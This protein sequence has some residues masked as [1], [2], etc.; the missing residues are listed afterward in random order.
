MSEMRQK[1]QWHW[2]IPLFGL[3]MLGP[4]V[5]TVALGYRVI[6]LVGDVIVAMIGFAFRR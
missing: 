2:I 4:I 6:T 5:L 1:P 3:L